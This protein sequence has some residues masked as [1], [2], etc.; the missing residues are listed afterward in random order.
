MVIMKPLST[1][2]AIFA[3]GLLDPTAYTVAI[4]A[5]SAAVILSMY[6]V[7]YTRYCLNGQEQTSTKKPR[8]PEKSSRSVPL[9]LDQ[10]GILESLQSG[11]QMPFAIS[12]HLYQIGSETRRSE[13]SRLIDELISAGLVELT[14]KPGELR[15]TPRGREAL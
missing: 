2:A 4:S 3:A 9:T 14:S 12:R 15:L 11:P 5:A 6:L 7:F 10:R 8:P 13:L 1:W